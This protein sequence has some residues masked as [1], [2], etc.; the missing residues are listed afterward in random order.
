MNF[1]EK[2]AGWADKQGWFRLNERNFLL[3]DGSIVSMI[4]LN[5]RLIIGKNGEIIK[6]VLL[7]E[8]C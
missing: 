8:E 1:N 4:E 3:P 2:L 5:D 6:T 7:E